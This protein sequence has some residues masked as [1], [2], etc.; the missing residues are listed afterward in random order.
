MVSRQLL[1]T[2]ALTWICQQVAQL[3]LVVQEDLLC[4][5]PHQQSVTQELVPQK[6]PCLGASRDGRKADLALGTVFVR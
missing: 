1:G 5:R 2:I 3:S 6:M 4:L